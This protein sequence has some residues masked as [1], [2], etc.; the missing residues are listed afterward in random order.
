M[1][2]REGTRALLIYRLGQHCCGA[3]AGAGTYAIGRA[4]IVYFS[5]N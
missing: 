1:I 5:E 4:A 2:L 3:V